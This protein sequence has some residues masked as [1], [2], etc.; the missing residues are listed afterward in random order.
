VASATH[1]G[2]PSGRS[3]VDHLPKVDIHVHGE[4]VARLGRIVASKRGFAAYDHQPAIERAV[5]EIPAGIERLYALDRELTKGTNAN[6]GF[7]VIELLEQPD[8]LE[9]CYEMLMEEAASEGALLVEMRLGSGMPD[10]AHFLGCF[11]SAERRV[12][13]RHPGFCAEPIIAWM[14]RRPEREVQRT[15]SIAADGIAGI[16]FYPE[17]D[18]DFSTIYRWT[19]LA[20]DA[21]LPIT[22]HAGEFSA[23]SLQRALEI[24]G[25]KRLGHAVHAPSLPGFL[26]DVRRR[27][28]TVE[29]AMTSNIVLG[30]VASY[31]THP[32]REFIQ[33]GVP[34]TLATDDPIRIGTSIG[35]EYQ[36][37]AELGFSTEELIGFTRNGIQAS[38]T[39]E[40]RKRALLAAL[41]GASQEGITTVVSNRPAFT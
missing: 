41:E 22:C 31:E 16:D 10:Y 13:T 33:A 38:F 4:T 27:G 3:I 37:A 21:G 18:P 19:G 2:P 20:C 35:R 6:A 12:Q 9:A 26:D 23:D 34:V 17:S 8:Y 32:I 25:L 1:G 39:S 30:N 40:E 24:P 28:I 5:V 15:L 29:V 11:R 14:T 7:E 36:H